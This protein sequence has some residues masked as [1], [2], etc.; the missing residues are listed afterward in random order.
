MKASGVSLLRLV[1]VSCAVALSTFF[2]FPRPVGPVLMAQEAPAQV[3]GGAEAPS[4]LPPK[5][6]GEANY[7]PSSSCAECHGRIVEQ[8]ERSTHATSYEDPVFRAQYFKELLPQVPHSRYLQAEARW[9]AAC[10]SPI[11]F[12][13][14]PDAIIKGDLVDARMSGVTCDVCHRI[15]GFEG[16]SPQNGNYVI[17]PGQDKFGPF[18]H[19]Y[20]WHHVY[21]ALQTR[22][23]FCGIC[24]NAVNHNGLEIKSTYTEW[25]KSRF[26]AENIQCQDCHMTVLGF[27]RGGAPV[28]ESGRAASMTVGSAPERSALYTHRFPGAHS[29]TQVVGAITLS[30][31]TNPAVASPGDEV[32]V[33]IVVDNSRTGHK[34]PSGSADLR[35]LWL[36]VTAEIDGRR[37]PVAAASR[38]GAG[39]HDVVGQG[40]FDKQIL[41]DDI[42]AGSRIYRSIYVDDKGR[43]CLRSYDAV[44]IVFDN[45]LNASE[46][47]EETYRFQIPRRSKATVATLHASLNYL[48]YP[49]AFAKGLGLSAAEPVEVASVEREVRLR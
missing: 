14:N 2:A 6:A 19:K 27:L 20:N 7:Q 38:P 43:Q 39:G 3:V 21:N 18:V 26:A 1:R 29:K 33:R 13:Q 47:R 15:S 32:I 9:C 5:T 4:D 17:S 12:V 36:A 46:T 8:Y 11:A 44:Q 25:R 45:R 42:P 28:R 31:E 34:M 41:G 35:Q 23:E 40:R 49:S 24:H 30:M 48:A 37:M 16:N 10:H 22:S